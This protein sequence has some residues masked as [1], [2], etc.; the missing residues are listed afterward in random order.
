MWFFKTNNQKELIQHSP[1]QTW[2]EL[3]Y[4]TYNTKPAVL[5]NRRQLC[6]HGA[7]LVK[8]THLWFGKGKAYEGL[9]SELEHQSTSEVS[10]KRPRQANAQLLPAMAEIQ[11]TARHFGA[12]FTYVVL[13][14]YPFC[15]SQHVTPKHLVLEAPAFR[16]MPFRHSAGINAWS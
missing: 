11:A 1:K 14:T 5:S 15:V 3:Y 9:D 10:T 8:Q 6:S 2:V 12:F 13:I 4:S 7:K 16:L